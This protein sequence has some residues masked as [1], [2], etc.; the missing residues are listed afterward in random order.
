MTAPSTGN[1][2][3]REEAKGSGYVPLSFLKHFYREAYR[4]L[5]AILPEEKIIIFHDGFRL[6]AWNRFFRTSGMR[7]VALDTH[8][9]IFAMEHFVPIARPWVYR[10]YLAICRRKIRIAGK[11]VP[12]IVGEWCICNKYADRMEKCVM[13]LSDYRKKQRG[14]YRKI[15]V[16]QLNVW[17]ETQGWFYWNY[18]LLRDRDVPTDESWKE[19]WDL[20]RCVRNGWIT[21][22]IIGGESWVLPAERPE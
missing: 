4:R 13:N 3:D 18:Q 6:T 9:Y 2:V 5:R 12:V 20:C 7:N 21:R 11:D 22:K 17:D 16:M 1:A 8:I 10:F 14:K 15:A 19:S